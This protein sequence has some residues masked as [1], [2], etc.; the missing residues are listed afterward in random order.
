[1]PRAPRRCPGGN[2]TC[3]ER[4]RPPAKY[5]AEHTVSWRTKT[6]SSENA[7][8]PEWR[9]IQ[10]KILDRDGHRCQIRY[11]GRCIGTATTVDHVVPVA[12]GGTNEPSNLR[13]ACRPCNE[14]KGRTADRWTW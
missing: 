9:R 7:Q 3:T 13:A 11:E 2:G 12:H 10:P 5:C 4:I 14:H 1:M 8:T 6:A